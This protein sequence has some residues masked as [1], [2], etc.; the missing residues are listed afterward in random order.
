[1]IDKKLNFSHFFKKAN[2]LSFIAVLISVFLSLSKA[3][4]MEL[5]LKGV[6]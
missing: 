4:T 3:L 6:L 5:I 2:I 1:M